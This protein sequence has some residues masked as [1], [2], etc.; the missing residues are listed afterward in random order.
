M[1][2]SIPL[3]LLKNHT[4]TQYENAA[5]L[6]KPYSHA[7]FNMLNNYAKEDRKHSEMLYED[8][9]TSPD[10]EGSRHFDNVVVPIIFINDK[11]DD[12][13]DIVIDALNAFLWMENQI[14]GMMIVSKL[15]GYA[16]ISAHRC[17]ELEKALEG[18]QKGRLFRANI[19]GQ[20]WKCAVCGLVHVSEEAQEQTP[21]ECCVCGSGQGSFVKLYYVGV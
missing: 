9:V 8:T 20:K 10:D 12:V 16:A 14:K 5:F 11:K 13:E 6:V 7:L 19:S 1:G 4:A 3:Y 21:K 15:D 18:V 17:F 2:T